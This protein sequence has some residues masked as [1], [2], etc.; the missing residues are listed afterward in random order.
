MP[1]VEPLEE[2][3]STV[4][5]AAAQTLREL[6]AGKVDVLD[7][8]VRRPTLDDVFLTLTGHTAEDEEGEAAPPG[9]RGQQG[10]GGRSGRVS[11]EQR[12]RE[13][14]GVR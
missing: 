8:A 1:A 12:G 14:A 11:D 2:Y 7:V 9:Q 6:D 13:E 5:D 4:D 10:T 3:A